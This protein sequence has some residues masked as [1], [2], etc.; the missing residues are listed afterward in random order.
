VNWKILE[1]ADKGD[2]IVGGREYVELAAGFIS[3][4]TRARVPTELRQS[5]ADG[6]YALALQEYS[7]PAAGFVS[8]LT[9]AEVTRTCS[10]PRKTG[11]MARHTR[12]MKASY[13]RGS[14][15]RAHAIAFAPLFQARLAISIMPWIMH[16]LALQLMP[17]LTAYLERGSVA[18]ISLVAAR[19]TH[20][21]RNYIHFIVP[22]ANLCL[23]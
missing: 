17:V 9:R 23:P 4:K 14:T 21:A 3:S 5:E 10:N 7:D 18:V 16:R 1:I 20:S 8:R 13:N 11:R 15:M 12:N 22:S 2:Y 19:V 6:S